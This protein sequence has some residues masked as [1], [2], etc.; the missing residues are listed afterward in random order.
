MGWRPDVKFQISRISRLFLGDANGDLGTEVDTD[1]IIDLANNQESTAAQVDAAVQGGGGGSDLDGGVLTGQDGQH[2]VETD[3]L[4]NHFFYNSED[5]KI[6]LMGVG[7]TEVNISAG[8]YLTEEEGP[9]GG[10]GQ[11]TGDGSAP[12]G[13]V[14][15]V[16]FSALGIPQQSTYT[17]NVDATSD[18]YGAPSE[19]FDRTRDGF[20]MRFVGAPPISSP[21]G[22]IVEVNPGTTCR[23]LAYVP[24]ESFLL[25]R[26][27]DFL[28]RYYLRPNAEIAWYLELVGSPPVGPF[29]SPEAA[30]ILLKG[31]GQGNS[32]VPGYPAPCNVIGQQILLITAIDATPIT[33]EAL[34]PDNQG[35]SG[36]ASIQ[37][38]VI[39]Q[40]GITGAPV[41]SGGGP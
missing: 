3:E 6:Q 17:Y 12:G 15:P 32:L 1:K 2:C 11:S 27:S 23:A 22:W 4:G 26:A 33:P 5:P 40:D 28:T 21:W 14:V 29:S 35:S 24:E 41:C 31:D 16:V 37:V 8:A 18:E 19:I 30:V 36:Y 38:A 7:Q 9:W 13:A 39:I 34:S 25:F 20:K 10:G